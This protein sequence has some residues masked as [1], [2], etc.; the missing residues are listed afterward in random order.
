LV[1]NC[2]NRC[3]PSAVG[4]SVQQNIMINVFNAALMNMI[5]KDQ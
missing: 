1:V 5:R 2:K 4:A 3:T